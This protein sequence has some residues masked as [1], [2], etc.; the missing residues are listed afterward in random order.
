M[1]FNHDVLLEVF[2]FDYV[3]AIVR[4]TEDTVVN[5]TDKYP[6]LHLVEYF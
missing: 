1:P 5:K 4:D 6:W 2:I 3:P